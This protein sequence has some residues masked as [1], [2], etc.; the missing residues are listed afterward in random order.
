MIN[1]LVPSIEGT[2]SGNHGRRERLEEM[3]QSGELGEFRA[4]SDVAACLMS[5]LSA[6]GWHGNPRR[7]AEALPHFADSLDATDLRNV[8]A[9]LNYSC[10]PIRLSLHEIDP[11]LLPCVFIPDDGPAM[12]LLEGSEEGLKAFNGATA[13][14]EDLSFVKTPGTAYFIAPVEDGTP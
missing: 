7:L 1:A 8:L 14:T 2:G 13:E 12:V 10:S 9:N 4:V 5:L 11:R 6:L 3:L